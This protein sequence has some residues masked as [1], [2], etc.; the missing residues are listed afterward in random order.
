MKELYGLY[1]KMEAEETS[2]VDSAVRQLEMDRNKDEV[3]TAMLRS[4]MQTTWQE[5][6]TNGSPHKDA[7]RKSP[8][9]NLPDIPT[10]SFGRSL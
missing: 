3:Q 1:V 10:D 9:L 7:D 5:R 8:P 6:E 4:R 2:P